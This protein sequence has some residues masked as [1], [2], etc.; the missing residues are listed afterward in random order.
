MLDILER[1][2]RLCPSAAAYS[3]LEP[4]RVAAADICDGGVY[5]LRYQMSITAPPEIVVL[6][7]RTMHGMRRLI[8]E[9]SAGKTYSS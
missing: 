3:A 6:S 4:L 2:A 1:P 8:R 9:L 7:D 5:E